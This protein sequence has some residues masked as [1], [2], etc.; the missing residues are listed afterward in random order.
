VLVAAPPREVGEWVKSAAGEALEYRIELVHRIESET[1][2]SIPPPIRSDSPSAAIEVA[3]GV[4]PRP[5]SG[6]LPQFALP[7]HVA[8]D[9]RETLLRP[10]N[11]EAPQSSG[12]SVVDQAAEEKRS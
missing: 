5:E 1:S 3:S 12:L 4:A 8:D 7:H 10:P 9:E 11:P 6:P 2:H